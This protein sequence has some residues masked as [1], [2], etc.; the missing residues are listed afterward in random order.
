VLSSHMQADSF[1][2]S[3]FGAKTVDGG[4]RFFGF[5]VAVELP[6]GYDG[7]FGDDGAVVSGGVVEDKGDFVEVGA[8]DVEDALGGGDLSEVVGGLVAFGGDVNGL[9][10]G[11]GEEAF[12]VGVDGV[13]DSKKS[14]KAAVWV[15]AVRE[16][17]AAS[18]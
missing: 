6:S 1:P 17:A 7:D 12:F 14:S 18:S 16:L 5:G 3:H 11:V 15:L 2:R 4:S 8:V 9:V 10:G 13:D